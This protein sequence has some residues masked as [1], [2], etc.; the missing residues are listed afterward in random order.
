MR[1]Q[2][3]ERNIA[4]ENGLNIAKRRTLAL[5]LLKE[6]KRSLR[7]IA[8]ITD[9]DKATLNRIG[10]ILRSNDDVTL[11]KTLRP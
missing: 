3:N 10:E 1:R 5:R 11:E 4:M 2:A 9:V 8:Q 6:G 7:D